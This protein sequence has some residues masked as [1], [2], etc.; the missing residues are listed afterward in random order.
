MRIRAKG[1]SARIFHLRL[2]LSR[3]PPLLE[4]LKGARGVNCHVALASHQSA[5]L[6]PCI[7]PISAHRGKKFSPLSL[8]GS[9]TPAAIR[10]Q[11]GSPV[12][13]G[14][15]VSPRSG[16]KTY[17][18]GCR[19]RYDEWG[20]TRAAQVDESSLRQENNPLAIGPN[21]VIDLGAHFFPRQIRGSKAILQNTPIQEN[22]SGITVH[23]K[24]RRPDYRSLSVYEVELNARR[25]PPWFDLLLHYEFNDTLPQRLA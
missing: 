21:H 8:W 10:T 4:S 7:P 23:D 19:D 11:E 13:V 3:D 14:K 17:L 9:L 6:V 20:Q 1:R 5:L 12:N 18:C 2:C 16:R 22:R 24:R 25:V 15:A